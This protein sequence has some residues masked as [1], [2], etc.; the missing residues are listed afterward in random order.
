[1]KSKISIDELISIIN[2]VNIIDIRSVQSYNNNHIPN[3]INIPFDKLILNPEL[4][5]DKNTFYYIYCQ[6]GLSSSNVCR[7]LNNLGYKL[8]NIDGGY[9]NWIMNI[10]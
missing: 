10:K 1:M 5:L 2:Q 8:I 6:K 4:Y 7:I 3:S 9:E